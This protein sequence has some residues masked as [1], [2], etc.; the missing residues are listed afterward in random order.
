MEK[1]KIIH[2]KI[3][4]IGAGDAGWS[5]I[6]FLRSNP[7]FSL[8]NV[9][10][11]DATKK[12]QYQS[13]NTLVGAGHPFKPI[14]NLKSDKFFD[15]VKRVF[16]NVKMVHPETNTIECENQEKYSYD[17]L[18]IAAG[19]VINLTKIKGLEECLK[20]PS[21]PVGTNYLAEYAL[22]FRKLQN[23]FKGGHAIFTQPASPIK[24][25]GAPQ[26]IMYLCNDSWSSAKFFRSKL[27]FRSSFCTGSKVLFVNPFYE[28]ALYKVAQS[29]NINI[30][31]EHELVEIDGTRRIAY[32]KSPSNQKLIPK[33]FDI[34]HVTP[35]QEAPSFIRNSG[36]SNVDGFVHVN[37]KTLQHLKYPNIFSIGDSASLPTSKTLS[38]ISEQGDVLSKNINSFLKNKKLESEYNGYTACPIFV[39]REKLILCEFG[40]DGK[41]L[42]TFFDDQRKPS[43]ML[44]YIKSFLMPS[45]YLIGGPKFMKKLRSVYCPPLF[46]FLRF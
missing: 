17:V 12:F 25:G 44:F 1:D 24:C 26:K 9:I 34:M 37:I 36:L 20:D 40:Y 4:I 29:Y 16:S 41:V 27:D 18:V 30:N 2:S 38:G 31:L 11:I 28:E 13:I 35:I 7:E 39:G 33:S 42:P 19:I 45:L 6:Q 5:T 14:T 23:D 43:S 8:N 10:V 15:G 22:K 32:F 3:V 46:K 21:I